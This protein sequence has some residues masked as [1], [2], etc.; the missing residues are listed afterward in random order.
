MDIPFMKHP[1]VKRTEQIMRFF[2]PELYLQSNS[3][4]DEVA[5]RADEA[6]EKA[7]KDYQSHLDSIRDRMPPEVRKVAEL[8]LHDAEVLGFEQKTQLFVPFPKQPGPIGCPVAILFLKQD[9]TIESLIYMLADP[10]RQYP[11]KKGWPFSKSRKHW[12][13][14]EVDMAADHPGVFLHRILFSD[15]C[16]VGIPFLSAIISSVLLPEADDSSLKKRI[17]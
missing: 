5:D 14:D 16:V 11:A 15:G 4:D 1:T 10:V 3:E 9:R 17:A 7:L 6:W 8:C 13:Y 2:T 12:L